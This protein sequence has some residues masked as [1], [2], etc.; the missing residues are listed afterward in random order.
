MAK[1]TRGLWS[2]RPNVFNQMSA[3]R[4][5]IDYDFELEEIDNG[6]LRGTY[7]ELPDTEIEFT[8]DPMLGF[9]VVSYDVRQR[10][11]SGTTWVKNVNSG[12]KQ[13][14]GAWF[15][16]SYR[17]E[18]TEDGEF[19]SRREIVFDEFEANPVVDPEEFNLDKAALCGSSR[20]IDRRP[21]AA[22]KIHNVPTATAATAAQLDTIADAV[23]KMPARNQKASPLVTQE[24]TSAF[25][26]AML[27]LLTVLFASV[28]WFLWRRR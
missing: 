16:A 1:A 13:S 6:K 7:T 20:I 28:S 21:Q 25:R 8:A 15:I 2:V 18:D 26:V 22:V 23:E 12:W 10:T 3:S 17:K 14:N 5:I 27:A 19:F 4:M 9:N 11:D 24:E